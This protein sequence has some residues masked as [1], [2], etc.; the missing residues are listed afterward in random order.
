MGATQAGGAV[1]A[2]MRALSTVT[3]REVSE[4]RPSTRVSGAG[5]RTTVL[6]TKSEDLLAAVKARHEVNPNRAFQQS[7]KEGPPSPT[8]GP[9]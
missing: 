6:N 3:A 4:T 7:R 9:S 2:V 5:S 1:M 8:G